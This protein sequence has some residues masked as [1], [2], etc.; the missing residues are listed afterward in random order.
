[1]I[2]SQGIQSGIQLC[3]AQNHK[4]HIILCIRRKLRHHRNAADRYA[5]RK[6]ILDP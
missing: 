6:L 5:G 4:N 3:I 2:L 1:M